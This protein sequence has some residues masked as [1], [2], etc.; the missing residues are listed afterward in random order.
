MHSFQRAGLA[1]ETGFDRWHLERPM[2]LG[3]FVLEQVRDSCFHKEL[4]AFPEKT[5]SFTLLYALSGRGTLVWE[6][7][8]ASFG[9]REFV[10]AAPGGSWKLDTSPG[11]IRLLT[12]RFRDTSGKFG[13]EEISSGYAEAD[14]SPVRKDDGTLEELLLGLQKEIGFKDSY[15]KAMAE[16]YL[17]QI[18]VA[19]CRTKRAHVNAANDSAFVPAASRK[20]LAYQAVAFLDHSLLEIRELSQLAGV[21]GYSY[22]HLS[23]VFRLEMGESLQS[24]WTRKRI[25]KAMRLLQTGRTTVTGVAEKLHYQSIHSFSK[26]FKK[27]AGLTPSDYQGLYGSA[28]V[29]QRQIH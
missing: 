16:S 1:A 26:A 13:L 18:A 23:H 2:T 21:L 6:G 25:L 29:R 27:I 7:R 3:N 17:Q 10:L 9:E 8:P 19:L 24:Y 20:E 22:S 12:M 14:G 15:T 11:P 4:Q 5:K 28:P